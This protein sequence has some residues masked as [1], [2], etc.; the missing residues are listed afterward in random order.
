MKYRVLGLALALFAPI[1]TAC[2][3]VSHPRLA[4][5]IDDLGY[6]LNRGLDAANLPAPLTL[7]IIPHT[8]HA[9]SIATVGVEQGKEIMV[10]MPMEST[11]VPPSDPVVLT[12]ALAD[13]DF[14][15]TIDAALLSVPGA[16]GVNNHMGSKL[17]TNRPLMERFMARV[18]DNSMFFIDSRTTAESV[19]ADVATAMAV[20]NT[21][22]SVF[23]DNTRDP[24]Q[25]ENQLLEAVSIALHAGDA[26]AIGH[27][28]P[29]TLKVLA[30]ALPR[31]PSAVQLV[32]ASALTGCRLPQRLTSIP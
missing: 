9:H 13:D 19:A 14:E 30:Q 23:L 3:E 7:S 12:T 16:T 21:E 22:R 20:P 10:H 26:V 2:N 24:V 1:A 17:T 8:P 28:Y 29:E 25:I 32:P 11:K 27:P 31:L 18:L 6:S 15:A 4:I 5:I